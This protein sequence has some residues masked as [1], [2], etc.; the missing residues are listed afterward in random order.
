MVMTQSAAA[1]AHSDTGVLSDKGLS[2]KASRLLLLRLMAQDWLF[3][4]GHKQKMPSHQLKD[5]TDT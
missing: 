2:G 4:N 3:K 1:W 5:V